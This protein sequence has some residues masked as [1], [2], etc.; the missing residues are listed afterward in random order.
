MWAGTPSFRSTAIIAVPPLQA[1]RR[2]QLQHHAHQ[3]GEGEGEGEGAPPPSSLPG[4]A[5][6]STLR[7]V[8][9]L[10]RSPLFKRLTVGGQG[11][12]GRG[13]NS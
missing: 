11:G 8:R 9:I 10:M 3:G 1:H 5:L 12:G 7:A 2:H 4:V 13:R 6:G